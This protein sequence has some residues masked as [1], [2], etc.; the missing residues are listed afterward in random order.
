M[1]LSGSVGRGGM[2]LAF[3]VL[4]VQRALNIT[5]DQD[6]LSEITEDGL[7]GPETLGAIQ[8][9]QRRHTQVGDDRIDPHGATLRELERL[10]APVLAAQLRNAILAIL[11]GLEDELQARGLQLSDEIQLS[12]DRIEQAAMLLPGGAAPA[13]IQPAIYYPD[14]QKPGFQLAFAQAAPAVAAEAILLALLALIALLIMIQMAP[15]M[16]RALEDLLRQIQILMS[17]LIDKVKEAIQGIEDL[18]K[19]NSKAGMKC[20][21]ELILF[22]Q[23]SQQLLDLLVAP[24]AQDELGRRRLMKQLQEL[25]EKWQKALDALLACL[26]AN[27]AT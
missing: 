8:E 26:L 19:R 15:A 16:G 21:A 6:G 22:R 11:G 13:D 12:L 23:L 5:R 2:N 4:R 17:K 9:F 10:A 7:V 18:V 20:S 14:R 3:D 25:F 24:R 27:G 1:N